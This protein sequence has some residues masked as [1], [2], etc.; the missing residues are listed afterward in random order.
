MLCTAHHNKRHNQYKK[1]KFYFTENFYRYCFINSDLHLTE[2]PF[3]AL[4]LTPNLTRTKILTQRC[5]DEDPLFR[6]IVFNFKA[7]R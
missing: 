4:K 5:S 6:F 2:T 3:L 1:I 7:F